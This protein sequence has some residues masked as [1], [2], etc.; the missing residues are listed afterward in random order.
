MN[1]ILDLPGNDHKEPVYLKRSI[2]ISR[3]Y[4]GLLIAAF[5]ISALVKM[6]APFSDVLTAMI[7]LPMFVLIGLSP[8]GVYYS[9]KSKQRNEG[10]NRKRVTHAVIHWFVFILLLSVILRVYL[11]LFGDV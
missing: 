10:S 7:G 9:W 8:W 6:I 11:D 4:L 5:L 3:I 2:N 1:N